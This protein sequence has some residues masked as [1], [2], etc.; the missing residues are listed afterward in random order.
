MLPETLHVF[1]SPTGSKEIRT[2][3]TMLLSLLFCLFCI[4]R[5]GKTLDIDSAPLI[6]N[7]FIE[8]KILCF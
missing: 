2:V 7:R 1:S 8:K 5:G 4:L 6:T 3:V